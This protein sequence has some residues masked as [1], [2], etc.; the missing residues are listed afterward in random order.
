MQTYIC[1]IILLDLKLLRYD[2]IHWGSL[3]IDVASQ[4][5]IYHL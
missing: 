4:K 5:K 2:V 3:F 1:L